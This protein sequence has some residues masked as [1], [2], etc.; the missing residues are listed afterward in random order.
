MR[1][2]VCGGRSFTNFELVEREL[3]QLNCNKPI[4]VLIHGWIGPAASVI[5]HWAR[6]ND[7]PIVRYPPN[8]ELH[9]KGAETRRN[10]FMLSDSRPGLVIAFPGGPDTSDLVRRALNKGVAVLAVPETLVRERRG[11]R[12]RFKHKPAKGGQLLVEELLVRNA[13]LKRRSRHIGTAAA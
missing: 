7:I 2:I 9:G 12:S 8:W 10:E 11:A 5:E 4:S 6:E 1:L 13:Q 3:T